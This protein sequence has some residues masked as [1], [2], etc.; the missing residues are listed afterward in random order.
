LELQLSNRFEA[1]TDYSDIVDRWFKLRVL[2]QEAAE[3]VL[4]HAK[5]KQRLRISGTTIE[6]LGKKP[7]L[8]SGPKEPLRNARKLVKQSARSD[9]EK[10]WSQMAF[11]MQQAAESHNL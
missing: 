5:R 4:G 11:D 1:L 9:R 6:L 10:Y 3:Q 7:P 8:L 2:T